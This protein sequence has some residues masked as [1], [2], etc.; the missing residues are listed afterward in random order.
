MRETPSEK[1]G[2][3]K[4]R[5][6]Y[7]FSV[8]FYGLEGRGEGWEVLR[9]EAVKYALD[10]LHLAASGNN[11]GS[12][13]P[14]SSLGGLSVSLLLTISQCHIRRKA[15]THAHTNTCTHTHM[16]THMHTSMCFFLKL[17]TSFLLKALI[18]FCQNN[19]NN[20]VGWKA[21]KGWKVTPPCSLTSD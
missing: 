8:S 1:S 10:C 17:T 14:L 11:A 20:E 9:D 18:G 4:Q 13:K 15:Y 2:I 3:L 5:Q 16:H 12:N 19:G 7:F 21:S 6:R